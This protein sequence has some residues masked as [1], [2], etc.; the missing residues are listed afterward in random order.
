MTN[1]T[2]SEW[3]TLFAEHAA[4]GMTIT[5]FCT[6]RNLNACYFSTRRKQ[7]QQ[8][9]A[10]KTVSPFVPVAMQEPHAVPTLSLQQGH[11]L[12]LEIPVSVSPGWLA[13]LVDRL[14]D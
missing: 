6:E 3:H 13:E 8:D 12:V 7:L 1:R 11:S 2:T 10:L 14:Q 4:S 9:K 5:A